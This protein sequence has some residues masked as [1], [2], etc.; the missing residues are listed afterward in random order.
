MAR[1]RQRRDRPWWLR[2]DGLPPWWRRRRPEP[3]VVDLTAIDL[4]PTALITDSDPDTRRWFANALSS[5]G[6]QVREARSG[7]EALLSVE[8]GSPDVVIL[9]HRLPIASGLDCAAVLRDRGFWGPIVLIAP[10][11]VA[12]GLEAE[13]LDLLVIS[14]VDAAGMLRAIEL[15]RPETIDLRDATSQRRRNAKQPPPRGGGRR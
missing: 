8:M 12:I 14:K 6:W 3:V 10:G 15:L 1:D 4:R 5:N 9:E 13:R 7:D 11:T 2:V